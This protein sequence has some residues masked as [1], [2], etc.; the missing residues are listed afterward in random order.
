MKKYVGAVTYREVNEVYESFEKAVEILGPELV[1]D[2]FV[3]YLPAD[4]FKDYVES[5]YINYDLDFNEEE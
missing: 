3:Q 4:T 5:L 2:E 1:L